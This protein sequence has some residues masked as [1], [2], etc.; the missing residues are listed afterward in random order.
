[1]E[2]RKKYKRKIKLMLIS[3]PA[4]DPTVGTIL[5]SQKKHPSY[6]DIPVD[7]LRCAWPDGEHLGVGPQAPQRTVLC[8][9]CDHRL[10]CGIVEG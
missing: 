3:T 6:D 9:T 4:D 10:V 7:H 8:Q 5:W 2:N 1:M